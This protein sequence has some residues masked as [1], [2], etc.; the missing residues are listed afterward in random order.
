MALSKS[1]R[2]VR[3]TPIDL[4]LAGMIAWLGAAAL[5]SPSPLVSLLGMRPRFEGWMGIVG[6]A[7][8]YWYASRSRPVFARWTVAGLALVT[9]LMGALA[10]LEMAGLIELLG[11]G[12][13]R[14]PGAD[15]LGQPGVC[16]VSDGF[17]HPRDRRVAGGR[18]H[19]ERTLVWSVALGLQIAGLSLAVAQAGIIGAAAG[20]LVLLGGLVVARPWS[21]LH[22]RQ[23]LVGIAVAAALGGLVPLAADRIAGPT[24]TL[25]A[26]ASV[27]A[28]GAG[29][30]SEVA[31]GTG[32]TRL[33]MWKATADLIA[34][35]PFL[36]WGP[37]TFAAS[38][39]GSGRSNRSR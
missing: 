39:R 26:G 37:D 15:D 24:S 18:T 7:V 31:T 33:L 14:T 17:G 35:R 11:S 10:F 19:L 22:L 36:G 3:V 30:P 4:L 23:A 38:T 32:K 16:R 2:P 29:A 5:L 21:G 34:Q 12:S 1:R 28:V 13:F 27:D 8:F 6:Y 9:A 25:S 20:V